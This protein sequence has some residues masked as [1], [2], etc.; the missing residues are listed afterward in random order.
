[1]AGRHAWWGDMHNRG[2]HSR[3]W[4]V[5]GYHAW[6]ERQPL[7]QAVH[8]LLECNLVLY[9]LGP[10]YTGRQ[11]QYCD[12][13]AIMLVIL[14]SLKTM[15]SLWNGVTTHYGETLLFSISA[16]SVFSV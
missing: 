9:H 16:V 14:L 1:M 10:V 7:H 4:G 2:V 3:G 8:I 13:A 5:G 15:E 12:Y 11:H 6:Q